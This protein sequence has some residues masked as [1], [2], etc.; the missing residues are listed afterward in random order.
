MCL[1]KC[2]ETFFILQN[3]GGPLDM[4]ILGAGKTHISGKSH[5]EDQKVVIVF[6]HDFS[7][8]SELK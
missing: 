7:L 5:S 1:C 8:K 3:T 2:E 6:V 4:R